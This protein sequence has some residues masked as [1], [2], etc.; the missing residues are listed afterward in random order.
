MTRS[1][2]GATVENVPRKPRNWIPGGTYHV[3]SRGSNRGA[4][5]LSDADRSDFLDYA[6]VVIERYELECLAFALMSNHFHFMF[7]TPPLLE[8]PLSRALK[9]L[10]GTYSGRFNRRHGREAHAF[11]NRFGAVFQAT[12]EQLV[13]TARYIVCNPVE[14]GLCLHPAEW[15]WSSYSATA[16]LA[17]PP[18]FLR[19]KPLLSLFGPTPAI[20]RSRYVDFVESLASQDATICEAA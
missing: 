3:F 16:G 13:G 6:A 12:T 11:R 10:N 5:Y 7:R 17:T 2:L 14:A 15:P 8:A 9:D 4:L 20:A 1:K 19:V 18:R